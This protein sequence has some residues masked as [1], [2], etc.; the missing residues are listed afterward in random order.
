MTTPE[1]GQAQGGGAGREQPARLI[2]EFGNGW[3]RRLPDAMVQVFTPDGVFLPSPFDE[4]LE[5]R[6]AIARYWLDVPL[7]QAE[8][9][10]R[11]GEIF[12]AGPW[13]ATEFKCT[14]RRVRTGEWIEIAGALFCETTDGKISE[15]RMYWHRSPAPR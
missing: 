2:E 13:F 8:V 1:P 10:F 7:E 11:S 9:S 12:L 6:A 3:E 15:M 5:G 4:R 14:F